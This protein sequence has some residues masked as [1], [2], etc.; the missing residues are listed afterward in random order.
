[1]TEAEWLA[2][3]DPI[4]MLDH[5]GA[6]CSR[7]KLSVAAGVRSL[8]SVFGNDLKLLADLYEQVA[9]GRVG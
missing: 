7:R 5:L 3:T 2:C 1:M 9:N 6:P 8:A 4:R